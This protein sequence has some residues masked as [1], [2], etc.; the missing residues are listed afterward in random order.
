MTRNAYYLPDSDPG[1]AQLL[2]NLALNVGGYAATLGLSPAEVASVQADAAMF[3]YLLRMQ[4]AF[5]TF[6]QAVSAYKNQLRDAEPSETPS[7][8]PVAPALP[9]APALVNNGILWRTRRLVA[10]IKASTNY[11]ESIGE[12]LGIVGD[13]RTVDLLGLKPELKSRVGA[14]HPVI[15]W[16]KGT[17][18][19]L[20][21]Y[22]DRK[23]GKGFVFLTTD[24]QPDYIDKH[25]MPKGVESVVWE[26]KGIYRMAD[27]QVGQFSEPIQV[28]VTRQP[29]K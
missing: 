23:D 10:R 1:K 26:Y 21:I 17:A 5:K 15:I 13:E 3:K 6:K 7:P 19:A 14:V 4:E 16:K 29:G 25:P 27:K 11:N 9:A 20:D 24:T 2:T 22:A 12:G 18:S 28:T 8:L